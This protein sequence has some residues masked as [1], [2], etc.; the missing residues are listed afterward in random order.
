MAHLLCEE[1]MNGS[2]ATNQES[3]HLYHDGQRIAHSAEISTHDSSNNHL[4]QF[5]A[6]SIL[7][8]LLSVMDAV[9]NAWERDR[10]ARQKEQLTNPVIKSVI[11]NDR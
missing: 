8:S 5:D 9:P 10:R 1:N 6:A 3:L 4:P 2:L 11:G 7:N